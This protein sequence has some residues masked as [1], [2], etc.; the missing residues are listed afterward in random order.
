MYCK[1]CYAV[2]FMRSRSLGPPDR[3]FKISKFSNSSI[4]INLS[5]LRAAI[6]AKAGQGCK[7][8]GGQVFNPE[9]IDHD[10]DGDDLIMMMMMM[11]ISGVQPREDCLQRWSLPCDLL[12]VPRL[13]SQPRCQH[14]PLSERQ[15]SLQRCTIIIIIITNLF[16]KAAG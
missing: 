10:D 1:A 8:C 3:F 9:I 2:I 15:T 14:R 4:F 5:P 11:M 7:G 6:Q 12:Q 16:A 13:R